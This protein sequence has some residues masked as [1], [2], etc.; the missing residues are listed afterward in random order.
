MSRRRPEDRAREG[1]EL[2]GLLSRSS[3][4]LASLT[5]APRSVLTLGLETA[6]D[7]CSV[8]LLEDGHLLAESSLRLPRQHAAR[9]M[10]LV[11]DLL[12]QTSH[13]PTDLHLVAVSAGP[14]SYTGLRIGASTAKGLAM[15]ADARL[16]GVPSLEALAFRMVGVA[17]PGDRIVA[18]FPSRR[19]EVYAAGFEVGDRAVLDVLP[20]AEAAAVTLD[21]ARGWW[22]APATPT[23]WIVG[24]AGRALAGALTLEYARVLAADVLTPSAESVARLGASRAYDAASEAW[25]TDDVASFEPSYLKAFVAGKPRPLF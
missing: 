19:G 22:P 9:L 21:A 15:A 12:A 25:H 18:A 20:G 16:L 23:T 2:P 24:P 6:T 11:R 3:S 14:G 10:P 13:A 4:S 1:S 7:V 8:A 5:L 17:Q